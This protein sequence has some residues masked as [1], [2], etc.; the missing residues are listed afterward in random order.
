MRRYAIGVICLCLLIIAAG[1][2]LF[3]TDSEFVHEDG[4][5]TGVSSG[6]G[7]DRENAD[8]FEAKGNSAEEEEASV[9]EGKASN[10]KERTTVT[11]TEEPE[12]IS[13]I[14]PAGNSMEG[15]IR[16]PE[17]YKRTAASEGSLQAYLRKLELKPDG[18]PVML[19]DNT[20]KGNQS[21]H[22]AVF[23]FDA[24][25]GDLQQCADSIIRVYS[26]YY[27]ST[28][29]VDKI[30][31][32]LTNGFL[33]DYETWRNGGRI[34]VQGNDVTWVSSAGYDDSYEGFRS[35]LKQVMIYAGTLSLSEEG[36]L[37][38]KEELKTGDMIIKGGSPG[39]CVLVVDA[40]ENESGERCYLLAQGFMPAQEFHILNNP[41][42]SSNPWYYERDLEYPVRTPQYTFG[43]GTIKRWQEGFE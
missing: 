27:L 33:M 29:A 16:T 26:E 9:Q 20:E 13:L 28:G 37:I 43:E 23:A 40:G 4:R 8:A 18:S 15:R 11:P 22:A 24:G 38:D 32:H 31:F 36:H 39:H 41:A 17:G 3:T 34:K 19:F 5:N 10:Q 1:Y 25:D 7:D 12:E 30:R 2:Y 35:Y 6:S 42:D 14:D 21:A